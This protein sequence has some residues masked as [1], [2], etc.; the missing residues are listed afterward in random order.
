MIVNICLSKSFKSITK[1]F[2]NRYT[3]DPNNSQHADLAMIAT[4]QSPHCASEL[5]ENNLSV[6]Q[7]LFTKR[8]LR[9]PKRTFGIFS[10]KSL[11]YAAQVTF[12]QSEAKCPLLWCLLSGERIKK[13]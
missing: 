7:N 8:C 12:S 2:L 1:G 10:Y 4:F 3:R 6:P 13:I 5:I 9:A 11:K